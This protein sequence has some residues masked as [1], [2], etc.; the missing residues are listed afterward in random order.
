MKKRIFLHAL[1]FLMIFSFASTA[2][3]ISISGTL[4]EG[5][6][7]EDYSARLTVTGGEPVYNWTVDGLPDKLDFSSWNYDNDSIVISGTP[8]KYGE[9]TIK[10]HCMDMYAE[11]DEKPAASAN[12]ATY[13]AIINGCSARSCT[14]PASGSTAMTTAS[15]ALPRISATAAK[16]LICF[17]RSRKRIAN[18]IASASRNHNIKIKIVFIILQKDNS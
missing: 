13:I 7:D 6:I 5:T 4:P 10:V 16:R 3:A 9:F 14:G 1:I 11:E 15:S 12:R 17:L 8:K 18:R 2:F